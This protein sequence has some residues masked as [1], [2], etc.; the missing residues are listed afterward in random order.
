MNGNRDKRLAKL[1][2]KRQPAG[3]TLILWLKGPDEPEEQ[4]IARYFPEGVPQDARLIFCRWLTED[5]PSHPVEMSHAIAGSG[6][7]CCFS[8]SSSNFRASCST[9]RSS[10]RLPMI[11]N[12]MGSP[13]LV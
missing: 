1:E 10:K 9:P 3:E 13:L 2:L 6:H 8:R 7:G 4:A 11:C 5:G 12:P